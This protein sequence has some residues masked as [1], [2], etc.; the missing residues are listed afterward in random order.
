M[1]SWQGWQCDYC[2]GCYFFIPDIRRSVQLVVGPSPHF[3][4]T[5]L[6]DFHS[7]YCESTNLGALSRYVYGSG[8]Q[9]LYDQDF[10]QPFHN[11]LFH[12]YMLAAASREPCVCI[13]RVSCSRSHN[14]K[15]RKSSIYVDIVCAM[16][17]VLISRP[18]VP[19]YRPHIQESC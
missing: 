15:Q 4:I 7:T 17:T 11:C 16:S 3:S 5:V 12:A 1:P 2:K 18:T 6:A 19:P 14:L 8:A 9:R 10:E 13:F